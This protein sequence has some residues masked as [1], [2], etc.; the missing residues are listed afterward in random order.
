MG[1][2]EMWHRRRCPGIKP[3]AGQMS[4]KDSMQYRGC[5]DARFPLECRPMFKRLTAPCLLLLLSAFALPE[6]AGWQALAGTPLQ[7]AIAKLSAEQQAKL[8]AYETARIDFQRRVDAYWHQI[9]L[10]RKKRRGKFASGQAVTAA[11]YVEET[12][13]RLQRARAPRR[14]HGDPPQAAEAAGRAARARAR[15]RRLPQAG[16]GDSTASRPDA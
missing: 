1:T 6:A 10:K 9:E 15:R 12:A 14:N 8:K 4:D 3:W 7:D 13:A 16:R 2:S 5:L 11:D